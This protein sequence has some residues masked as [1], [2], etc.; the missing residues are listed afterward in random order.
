MFIDRSVHT[1]DIPDDWSDQAIRKKI[2]DE[3]LIDST[4]T[5]LWVGVETKGRKHIDW[6]LY[7]SMYD[8]ARNKQSGIL[9]INLPST[10]STYA[11]S[12]YGDEEK[13]LIYLGCK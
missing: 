9:V 13:E 8:G 2:R 1:R 6:E 7:S 11:I 4:V 3:Y 5:V 12:A 10:S